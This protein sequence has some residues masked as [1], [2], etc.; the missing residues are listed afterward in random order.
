MKETPLILVVDDTLANLEVVTAA[1]EDAGFE[2]AIA[3]DG[4]RAIKQATISQP[5]LI[6]LDVMMPGIDGFETCRRL[7][8]APATSEIPIIFMTALSDTIDKVR[9]FNLG[10]V[11]YVTK[12]FQE[13]E[14]LARVKTQLKLRSLQQSLEQQVEQRTA[15]LKA[16]LQ[17]VQQSQVQLVQSEKMAALGQLVAGVAHEINNPIN[18]IHGNLTYVQEYAEDLLSFL[19]LYHQHSAN[20]APELQ[21]AAENLDLEFIQYD[22]P[23]TLASMEIGT[24]RICEIVRSLRIFSRVDEVEC[25]A[26]DIHEGI[27]STLLILQHRLKSKPE[28]P[29]IQVIRDYGQLP[30]VECYA[31]S[32][33]QVFMNILVNAID[34][35]EELNVKRTYQ[36]NQNNPSQIT[37]RTS[38]IDHQWVQIAIA[39]NG[40]GIPQEIQQRIFDPFFTTKPTGKGTGMGMSISRQIIAEKHGGNLLCSSIPGKGAEFIIQIPI[41]QQICA[42]S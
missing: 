5:D 27:N 32:L 42:A 3:T 8:A 2:V 34:A 28:H 35:L 10:A 20:A 9:G 6:L 30:P 16:A 22:L 19:Q 14:L 11:D 40:S 4:E 29:E 21:I 13:A 15:E 24:Q 1:L 39:D 36:E 17:Q 23:K 18:F 33:N 37:I 25:K 12:P 7:K 31:G 41:R 38:V 26:V